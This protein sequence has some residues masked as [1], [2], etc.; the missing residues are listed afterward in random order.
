MTGRCDFTT[1]EPIHSAERI[2]YIED[3]LKRDHGYDSLT[4]TFWKRYEEEA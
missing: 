3:S 4:V 1:T 2:T